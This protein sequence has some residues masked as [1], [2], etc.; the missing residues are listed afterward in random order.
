MLLQL[1]II[2]TVTVLLLGK[3]TIRELIEHK[4]AVMMLKRHYNELERRKN[5]RNAS[6]F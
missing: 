2:C 6:P 4:L 1:T 3:E 5:H